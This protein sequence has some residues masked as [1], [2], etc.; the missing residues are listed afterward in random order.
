[1]RVEYWKSAVADLRQ[2][3]AYT[4]AYYEIRQTFLLRPTLVAISGR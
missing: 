3:A 2:T 4:A 1:M